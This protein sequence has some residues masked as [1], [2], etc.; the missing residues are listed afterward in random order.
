MDSP[1]TRGVPCSVDVA[2][3][4]VRDEAL[5]VLLVRRPAEDGEPFPERWSLP[6]GNID[7]DRDADLE[8]CASRKLLEETGVVAPH[9][10]QVASVGNA[11]RDPRGWSATHLYLAL[12]ASD[13]LE[14][15]SGGNA[16]DLHWMSVQGEAPREALAFDHDLLLEMALNRLRAKV[17]YTS[18]PVFLMP[19]D[20]T[21]SQLQRTYEIVLGRELEKKAF[22]T[23][24]L[25]ADLLDVVARKKTGPN[26]PAQYYRLKRRRESHIFARPFGSAPP[27]G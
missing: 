21:L 23:R 5:Q 24:I 13:Y 25:A 15:R 4:T 16:A 12:M 6:G 17:E 9:L 27:A 22:R 7:V 18:L 2:L 14:L 19:V 1:V 3:F 26:R 8:A 20:F 11:L 10:E